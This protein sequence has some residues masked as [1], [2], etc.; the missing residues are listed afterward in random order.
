MVCIFLESS[1]WELSENYIIDIQAFTVSI[2]QLKKILQVKFA[3]YFKSMV[4]KIE[5]VKQAHNS[6]LIFSALDKSKV[7]LYRVSIA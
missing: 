7:C 2:E 6:E 3:C 1:H 4:S 5:K